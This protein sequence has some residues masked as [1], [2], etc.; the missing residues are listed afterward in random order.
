MTLRCAECGKDLPDG[1]LVAIP[2]RLVEKASEDAAR[3]VEQAATI[4]ALKARVAALAETMPA[5]PFQMSVEPGSA[6]IE[7]IPANVAAPPVEW[8]L[9]PEKVAGIEEAFRGVRVEMACLPPPW[10][11]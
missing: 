4:E 9:S 6:I 1:K 3:V 2:Y 7:G 5:A 11:L 8:P 10:R